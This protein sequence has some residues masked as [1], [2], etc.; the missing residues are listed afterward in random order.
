MELKFIKKTTG[1]GLDQEET[2]LAGFSID[3][4]MIHLFFFFRKWSFRALL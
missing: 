4:E 2:F 3:G 1:E